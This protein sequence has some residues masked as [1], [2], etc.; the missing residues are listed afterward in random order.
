MNDGQNYQ[1]YDQD[2]KEP[3]LPFEKLFFMRGSDLHIRVTFTAQ[4]ESGLP[5][6]VTPKQLSYVI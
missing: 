4:E 3:E 6:P 1:T 5:E 2:C